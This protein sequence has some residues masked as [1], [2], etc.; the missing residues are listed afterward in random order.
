MKTKL[1][2]GDL[3]V[4]NGMLGRV[5]EVMTNVETGNELYRLGTSP[6]FVE[7]ARKADHRDIIRITKGNNN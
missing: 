4:W 2:Q 7:G 3:A 6:Q 5:T 1:E